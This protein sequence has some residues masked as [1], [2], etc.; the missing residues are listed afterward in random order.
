VP[1]YWVVDPASRS[2]EVNRLQGPARA[3]V[4]GDTLR[5]RPDPKL[6]ALA[7][8]VGDLFPAEAA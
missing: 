5:W 2:I 6:P 8:P 1:E 7:I 3:E 4:V